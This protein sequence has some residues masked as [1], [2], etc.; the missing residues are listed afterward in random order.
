MKD[1]RPEEI[2]NLLE[3]VAKCAGQTL[4]HSR[5]PEISAIVKEKTKATFAD[6]YL[7][8]HVYAKAR[9]APPAQLIRLNDE[10][11]EML[12]SF[13]GLESFEEFRRSGNQPVDPALLNCVGNWYSFVRCNSGEDH[14]LRSP[15]EIWLHR[16]SVRMRLKGKVREFQGDV[17]LEG[18][19]IYCLLS[20]G[21][22]KTLH[23]VFAVGVAQQ[24]EVL[25]GVFSGMSSAGDPICGREVLIRA[26]KPFGELKNDRVAISQL[27]GSDDV[28]QNQI[29]KYFQNRTGNILKA[30]Q[31]STFD[32][33]D[34]RMN[35]EP[36]KN[37]GLSRKRK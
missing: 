34:L 23:L 26:D 16:K 9:N 29:G 7:Y 11:I 5:F 24:P 32:I 25:Q 35:Y 28:M 33:S 13:L 27:I 10:H 21:K 19:C 8:K 31:A 14:V 30:G 15:V 1:Y 3:Q 36:L 37:D 18:G 6:N 2:L 22:N 12:I 20:S 17:N 4:V